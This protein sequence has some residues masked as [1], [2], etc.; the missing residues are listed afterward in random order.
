[1][2][3]CCIPG[4]YRKSSMGVRPPRLFP[5]QSV[6]RPE[7]APPVLAFA[8]AASGWSASTRGSPTCTLTRGSLL[9]RPTWALPALTFPAAIPRWSSWTREAPSP[10]PPPTRLPM[11]RCMRSWARRRTWAPSRRTR[12]MPALPTTESR[13]PPK[14][15]ESSSAV[16]RSCRLRESRSMAARRPSVCWQRAR[17]HW[18]GH[19]A[20]GL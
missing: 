14:A 1:M 11:Y 6:Y 9:Y 15:S 16:A 10:P 8:V 3:R 17:D 2:A 19:A 18:R 5:F 12:W 13:T 7:W 20:L 4:F